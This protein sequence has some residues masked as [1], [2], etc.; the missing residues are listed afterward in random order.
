METK[1]NKFGVLNEKQFVT[2]LSNLK[3][4]FAENI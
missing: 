1:L 4:I 2:N 3:S